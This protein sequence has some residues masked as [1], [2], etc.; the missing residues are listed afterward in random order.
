MKKV[1]AL[2]LTAVL[3]IACLSACESIHKHTSE[4]KFDQTHHWIK[5]TCSLQICDFNMPAPEEHVDSDENQLCDVCGCEIHKHT[6]EYVCDEQIHQFVYTCGCPYPDIAE[7]HID[8]DENGICDICKYVLP[9][10]E[11]TTY[12]YYDKTI[13]SFYYVCG[14]TPQIKDAKH[15]DENGDFVCDVCEY[16]IDI[17]NGDVAQIILNYEVQTIKKFEQENPNYEYFFNPV[18]SVSFYFILQNSASATEIVFVSLYLSYTV[19]TNRVDSCST[20]F[21]T[22]L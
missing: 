14:C 9:S 5:A 7:L 8:T 21:N 20:N 2:V 15:V 19:L 3:L 11:H 4:W 22:S 6:S 18:I 13:H 17:T 16:H 1:F 12:V 10:H